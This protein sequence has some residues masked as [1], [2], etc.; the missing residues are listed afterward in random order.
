M[1]QNDLLS[2]ILLSLIPIVRSFVRLKLQVKKKSKSD[3]SL[4]GFWPRIF[5]VVVSQLLIDVAM[6]TNVV[7][8]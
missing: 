5:H 2:K 6:M 4:R 3:F 7:E 1:K 8:N